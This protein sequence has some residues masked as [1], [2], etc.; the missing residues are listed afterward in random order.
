MD[1]LDTETEVMPPVVVDR[2]P[3]LGRGTHVALA[4]AAGCAGRLQQEGRVTEEDIAEGRRGDG[5][6]CAFARAVMRLDPAVE[7]INLSGENPTVTRLGVTRPVG[8]SREF[9]EWIGK[10]DRGEPVEPVTFMWG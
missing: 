5:A 4:S 2:S 10:F 8:V 3:E 6:T 7:A 9:V 1:T